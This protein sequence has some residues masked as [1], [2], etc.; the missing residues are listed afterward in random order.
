MYIWF[1][2]MTVS[3]HLQLLSRNYLLARIAEGWKAQRQGIAPGTSSQQDGDFGKWQRFLA[4]CNI[5]DPFLEEY[6]A[7]AKLS[8]V[9]A[10]AAALRRNEHGKRNISKL[11]GKTIRQTINNVC[12]S[13]RT[14]LYPSPLLE[15][16]GKNSL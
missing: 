8:L 4:C 6:N 7:Q 1:G 2:N 5:E 13:F 16:N 9:S 11:S 3:G 12:S 15:A 14:N 10:F